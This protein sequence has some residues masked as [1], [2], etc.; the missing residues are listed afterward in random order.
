MKNI[1]YLIIISSSKKD[2][3]EC[4]PNDAG[5]VHGKADILG[6]VKVLRDLSGLEGVPGAEEDENHVVDEREDERDGRDAA[7]LNCNHHAREDDLKGQ[8]RNL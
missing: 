7:G 5:A 2:W 4:Q 1:S 3:D 6:L 8:I